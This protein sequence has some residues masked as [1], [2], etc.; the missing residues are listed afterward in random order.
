MQ[1]RGPQKVVLLWCIQLM[2]FGA[3]SVI[4]TTWHWM[5]RTKII[6]PYSLVLMHRKNRARGRFRIHSSHIIGGPWEKWFHFSWLLTF[7]KKWIPTLFFLSLQMQQKRKKI[8][9]SGK[10]NTTPTEVFTFSTPWQGPSS[11]RPAIWW[12][13]RFGRGFVDFPP[14]FTQQKIKDFFSC[15]QK[16]RSL[17]SRTMTK[18]A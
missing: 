16:E 3:S 12:V 13:K 8:G 17:S 7:D 18:Y 2:I 6:V 14:W 5:H 11:S 10:K 15:T 9:M 1:D 4:P